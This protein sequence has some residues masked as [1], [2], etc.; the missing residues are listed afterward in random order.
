VEHIGIDLRLGLCEKFIEAFPENR[1]VWGDGF[2]PLPMKM[3]DKFTSELVESVEVTVELIMTVV[4]SHEATVAESLEHP[5]DGVAIVIGPSRKVCDGSR[6][7]EVIEHLECLPRQQV[8]EVDMR[9][10][11]DEVLIHFDGPCVRGNDSLPA[12]VSMRVEQSFF[13]EVCYATREIALAVVELRC[14]F[15]NRIATFDDCE[16]LEF[17]ASQH[18]IT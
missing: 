7:I 6:L 14:E 10:L 4:R 5:I 16:D 2:E 13:D 9:V 15:D 17:D 18:D 1:T 11:P 12:A 8:R 3:T